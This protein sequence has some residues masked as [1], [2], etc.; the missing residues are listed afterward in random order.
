MRNYFGSSTGIIVHGIVDRV[1]YSA[2]SYV[3]NVKGGF[4]RCDE[5][6]AG[7]GFNQCSG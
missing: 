7:G 1:G 3:G 6:I 5:Q 4:L 2:K